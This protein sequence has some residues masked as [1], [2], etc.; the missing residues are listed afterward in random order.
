MHNSQSASATASVLTIHTLGRF[1]VYQGDSLI[2]DAAWQRQKAKKLFKLLLLAPQRQMHKEQ[3]MEYLWP[4]KSPEAAANNLHRTLFI[5]RRVLQT[6]PQQTPIVL[7]KDNVISL[8]PSQIAWVDFEAFE[9][10]AA[11]A[12]QD[13]EQLEP[14]EQAIKLY[15]GDFLPEDL[16]EDWAVERRE[17]LRRTYLEMLKHAALLYA[18]RQEYAVAI[19]QLCTV[20]QH[21]PADESVQRTLMRLYSQVGERHLALRL[22]QQSSKFLRTE[23]GIEPSA[24]TTAVY[25]ALLQ[26]Q[27]PTAF[28]VPLPLNDEIRPADSQ[29]ASLVPMVGRSVEM[30][31][32][33]E[34][35]HLAQ[36]GHGNVMIIAG[37]QGIGKSRLADE[38]ATYARGL[39]FQVLK[40]A[41]FE[42]EGPLPY[43]PFV[44]AIR[45]SLTPQLI[46]RIQQR[47]G[48]LANDLAHL[49][50]EI[51][52]ANPKLGRQEAD[53]YELDI[54]TGNQERR[55][56]F[57]AITATLTLFSQQKPLLVI[58]DNMHAAG[59]SSLQLLHYLARQ[60]RQQRIL[61]LGIVDQAKLQR[62]QPITLVLSELQRNSLAQRMTLNRL[63]VDDVALLCAHLLDASIYNSTI[64]QSVYELTEGNPFF[65]QELIFSLTRTGK[66][67]RSGHT[68]NL[69]ADALSV[70]PS[71][72][73]ELIGLR[74]GQLSNDA[75]R[76]LGVAATIGNQFYAQTISLA[77][78][79]ERDRVLDALDE[80]RAEALVF[81]TQHGYRFQ[82]A[83]IRQVVYTEL[84]SERRA[85]LHEH[86]ARAIEQQ[87]GD[88]LDEQASVLA[89]HYEQAEDTANAIHYLQR[90]GHWARRASALREALEHY[91]R[92]MEL[93][94]NLP[95]ADSTG[96]LIELLEQ[97][98]LTHLAL[99]NF[100]AAIEDLEQ[101]LQA[102]QD[103]GQQHQVGVTL[104]RIGF[105]HYWAHRLTK[106]TK[107]L[108]QALAQAELL[109]YAELRQQALR[110]RDILNTTQGTIADT[111]AAEVELY[112]DA[113]RVTSYQAEELWGYA[114][115]AHLRY[116]FALALQRAQICINVGQATSNTFL[117]L[118]GFFI[119]GMS[120]AS[121]GNYQIALD[122]LLGA[123]KIS[124]DS[125][126]SFWRARL[127]NTIGWVYRELFCFDQALQYDL[128][129]L[130]LARNN[131]PRLTEA[132]GNALAN[133]ATT[134]WMLGQ[135]EQAQAY[136]QEGL[137]LAGHEPFMRWRYFTRMVIIQGWLA[138]HAGDLDGAWEAVERSL[139]LARHTKARKNIARSCMLRGNVLLAQGDYERARAALRHA[140]MVATNLEAVSTIWRCQL[141]LA[142][143]EQTIG[144]E[145]AA[146]KYRAAAFALIDDIAGRLKDNALQSHF[147][148]MILQVT[149]HNQLALRAELH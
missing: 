117:T 80:L 94:P 12:R 20:L 57:D 128:L 61:L 143:L 27:L 53:P 75:Y 101:L 82:H 133:L 87:A 109:N 146:Q 8:N 95:S 108:D 44:G 41:V 98:S 127:V 142:E 51:G 66:L 129:S 81:S 17:S 1:A 88:H 46:D 106:A 119:L 92:A 76:L 147:R 107:Y 4:E 32:L 63:N 35:V 123:L 56:L 100:D 67:T 6:T 105:A 110:L 42:G 135:H 145:E 139:E 120:Q 29:R 112:S 71:S 31:Q 86:V 125:G 26:E 78:N 36:Q 34:Y 138:L 62:G 47:L 103:N 115:L 45:R 121:L 2:E 148:E 58:L 40:G 22:Y 52:R 144:N 83:M 136:L 77:M 72:V 122:S 23:L 91:N 140:L 149:Q 54:S 85:W 113:S 131:T 49:L 16:Y 111:T 114:M 118:G 84:S 73:Q 7:F 37:E 68:W 33:S 14:A 10:Y 90:A 18:E 141:S 64:P 89:Y 38:L 116:D 79:W 65:V 132:E 69:D 70:V 124:E 50:P 93:L 102:Y 130:E 59:E 60:I 25:E 137:E 74:L 9:Q 97:R 55:R 19:E 13:A 30:Q 24:E 104:Y 126:D 11:L 3:L 5:L 43:A 15:T 28:E 39:R 134:S 21:E 96:L 99:S 48:P